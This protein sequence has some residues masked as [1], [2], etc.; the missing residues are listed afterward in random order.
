LRN[1]NDGQYQQGGYAGIIS[2][3][4]NEG[5]FRKKKVKSTVT[6]KDVAGVSEAKEEL[7]EIVDQLKNPEKYS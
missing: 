5:M 6:F 1:F 7:V 2:R 4:D 3:G